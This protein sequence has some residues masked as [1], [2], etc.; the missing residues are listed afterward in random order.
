MPALVSAYL[1]LQVGAKRARELLLTGRVFTAAEAL[2]Y[3]LVTEVV[4]PAELEAKVQQTLDVLV[5]NSPS[6][7]RATKLLLNESNRAWLDQ[8]LNAAMETN[9]GIRQ[10]PDFTEGVAAFLEKRKPVWRA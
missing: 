7:L 4:E 6:S 3:G 8:A 2:Q 5:A 1:T 10:T 9:S